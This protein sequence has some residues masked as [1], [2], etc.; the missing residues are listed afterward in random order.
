MAAIP[1][2]GK[3][4][5]T[6]EAFLSYLE[7]IRFA[8]WQPRFI[9]A[10]HTGSPTLANWQA[11]QKRAIPVSDE[12]WLK[13]LANYYGN[14]LGWSAGPHFFFTPKHFCVLSPP[15]RRGVHAASFNGLAWGVEMVGNYDVEDLPEDVYQRYVSGLACLHIATGLKV[16]PFRYAAQG[17]HFHR[18]DPKTSKQCAGRK[19]DRDAVAFDV[20]IAIERMTGQEAPAERIEPRFEPVRP[21]TVVG[22]AAN[23]TLNVRAEP[24][25][26]APVV[27]TLP[28]GATVSI[29]GAAVNGST[30]WLSIDI[31]GDADGWVAARYVKA[32]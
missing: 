9:V 12:Q 21:G 19:L 14:E 1:N 26:K 30:K 23:D 28:P 8:A 18:D 29:K 20:Q 4:F 31:P 27:L 3:C 22:V 5:G 25:G 10:H 15:D 16:M 13:N 17:M 11:W 7:G 24:S 6:P 2:V 32:A